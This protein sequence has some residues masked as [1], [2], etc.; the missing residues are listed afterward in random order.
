MYLKKMPLKEKKPAPPMR[1]GK[2]IKIRI[3]KKKEINAFEMF[4]HVLF[5]Y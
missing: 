3:E 2:K 4:H 1:S 5:D